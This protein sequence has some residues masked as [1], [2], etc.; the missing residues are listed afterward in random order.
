[1][2][3]YRCLIFR[4]Q[5]CNVELCLFLNQTKL[6][7]LGRLPF[8][9]SRQKIK[10]LKIETAPTPRILGSGTRNFACELPSRWHLFRTSLTKNHIRPIIIPVS[11]AYGL[12]IFGD[13]LVDFGHFFQFHSVI[14]SPL[15]FGTGRV[16]PSNPVIGK[17]I[18]DQI[19][20]D[21]QY[22]FLVIS[23]MSRYKDFFQFYSKT[24]TFLKCGFGWVLT[25]NPVIGI[26]YWIKLTLK[27]SKFS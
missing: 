14:Q 27:P 21:T 22:T 25:W 3:L 23:P 5:Y 19:D 18:L 1:M 20:P 4:R 10:F 13:F 2:C 6:N 7:I 17:T 24:Q 9:F 12:A 26:R 11:G 8:L 16:L 15:I